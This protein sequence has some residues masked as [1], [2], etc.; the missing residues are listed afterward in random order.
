ML[1]VLISFNCLS[2]GPPDILK[3]G[4][5][6]YNPPYEEA[7]T[8]KNIAF[9]FNIEIM[10]DLCSAMRKP[11]EFIPLRFD[12]L[13][14]ALNKN[15]VDLI[16]VGISLMPVNSDQYVFSQPYFISEAVFLMLSTNNT[17]DL[18]HKTVGI[19]K[20]TLFPYRNQYELI[21][22][23]KNPKLTEHKD[24]LQFKFFN[25]LPELLT[26]LKVGQV[27]AVILDVGAANYWIRSSGNQFKRIGPIIPLPKGMAIMTT[28]ANSALIDEV[29]KA[30]NTIES[31]NQ[32]L[33]IYEKYW[34]LI[35]INDNMKGRL[36][37]K[38]NQDMVIPTVENN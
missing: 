13:L 3:V 19:V 20:N 36:I 25:N 10:N 38:A 30:I 27:D 31:D 22:E 23:E 28:K 9:G 16:I 14:I 2:A 11:C 26:A 32:L 1:G 29:N 15:Q 35:N 5:L 6:V 34:Q 18:N 37:P 24:Q 7:L 33:S 12:E 4:T 8:H 21:Y 17:N